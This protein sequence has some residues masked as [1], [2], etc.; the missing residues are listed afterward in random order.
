MS[1][2]C[3]FA[4]FGSVGLWFIACGGNS[5]T[6]NGFGSGGAGGTTGGTSSG[7]GGDNL[8]GDTG[9]GGAA[10]GGSNT[11]GDGNQRCTPY[12]TGV[13]VGPGAC[14]GGR[15]C[16]PDGMSWSPCDCGDGAGGAPA[17]GGAPSGGAST[18]GTSGTGGDVGETGGAS[19]GG[20][21]TGGAATGGASSGGAS[22]GGAATGGTSTGGAATGGT[23][24][25]GAS[26]GGAATGGNSTGGAATGGAATGGAAT[27]GTGSDENSCEDTPTFA[28]WKTFVDH[29]PGERVIVQ[30]AVLQAGC[31]GLQT[32]VDY[33]FECNQTHT[34]N[35]YQDPW[36]GTSWTF[37]AECT[38]PCD[39]I[40]EWVGAVAAVNYL[41]GQLFQ[42]EGK[43]YS[44]DGTMPMTYLH[45]DCPPD[46]SGQSWCAGLY[47][48]SEHDGC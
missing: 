18:G 32:G 47:P 33:L 23:S 21:S 31:A 3:A 41:P 19:S 8:A 25:G 43:I 10:D 6:L 46:G 29:F 27:G 11:G 5:G 45:P 40:V 38:N 7:S 24:T 13:C 15:E 2:W 22:T 28:E 16:S 17:T 30:C 34:A 48:Y 4:L 44:Y 35:C 12:D 26:T 37:V 36:A 14:V 20:T 42:Y 39:S 1:R 9:A